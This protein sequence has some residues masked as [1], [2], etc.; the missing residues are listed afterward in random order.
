MKPTITPNK[1]L[2]RIITGTLGIR[3]K[4]LNIIIIT[5]ENKI[6]F[7]LPNL[8]IT[9][10]PNKDPKDTPKREAD[11]IKDSYSITLSYISG[12]PILPRWN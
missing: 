8:A 12:P 9:G 10:P 1:A 7:F 5:C 11:E 4:P 6:R 3:L 2:A